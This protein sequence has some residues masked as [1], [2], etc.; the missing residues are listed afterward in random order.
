MFYALLMLGFATG[1]VLALVAIAL[2]M[3]Y[4]YLDRILDKL[5][6]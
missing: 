1:T 6:L 3:K 2:D 5:G 4:G